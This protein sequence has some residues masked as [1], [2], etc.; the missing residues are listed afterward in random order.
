MQK[1]EAKPS[2]ITALQ[3]ILTYI[4]Y[5]T[6]MSQENTH[7]LMGSYMEVSIVGVILQYM[8]SASFGCS[9]KVYRVNPKYN[10][11]PCISL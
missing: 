9:Y 3:A 1:H 2:G 5:S 8:V 6:R 7:K 11:N 10:I 4:P